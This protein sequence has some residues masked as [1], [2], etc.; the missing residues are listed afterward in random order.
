MSMAHHLHRLRIQYGKATI[1]LMRDIALISIALTLCY[2]A[3]RWLAP[4]CA[5]LIC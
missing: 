2:F 4:Y 3:T 5:F 1:V